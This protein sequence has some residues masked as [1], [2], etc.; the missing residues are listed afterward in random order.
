MV[1][2]DVHPERWRYPILDR[3]LAFKY[4]LLECTDVTVAILDPDMVLLRPLEPSVW[5]GRGL[6][7]RHEVMEQQGIAWQLSWVHPAAPGNPRLVDWPVVLA[8][9][10]AA[11]IA[12]LWLDITERAARDGAVAGLFGWMLD[13]Y[14]FAAAAHLAG[15]ALDVSQ[16][17]RVVPGHQTRVEG[18]WVAH[19][20]HCAHG[21]DK[22]TYVP[23][24]KLQPHP[25]DEVYEAVRHQLEKSAV[26]RPV[27]L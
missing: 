7:T 26:A 15:V 13:M 6:A 10:D 14:A 19:Y 17:L 2:S 8:A 22:R 5:P 3:V 21:L 11:R 24:V 23:G 4:A 9:S 16:P 20:H 1:R 25:E 12:P 18:A 27:P